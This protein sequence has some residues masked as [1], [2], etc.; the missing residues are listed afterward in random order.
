MLKT[1]GL[2]GESETGLS[3]VISVVDMPGVLISND[4]AGRGG[5]RCVVSILGAT[6]LG[7]G[8]SPTT[9]GGRVT[10]GEL[11]A[12]GVL[13]AAVS[14]RRGGVGRGR[15]CEQDRSD[16]VDGVAGGDGTGIGGNGRRD[17]ALLRDDCE[18]AA[19]RLR[20]KSGVCVGWCA[21]CGWVASITSRHEGHTCG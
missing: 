18:D 19:E 16:G 15:G 1:T 5:H 10:D 2:M 6:G 11:L 12:D 20:E 4:R 13:L 17:R 9:G 21:Y 14:M 8:L 7:S 3:S